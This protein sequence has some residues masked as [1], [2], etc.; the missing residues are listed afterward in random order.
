M[1]WSNIGF[2]SRP[3]ST[4][5]EQFSPLVLSILC[6]SV[7]FHF[8]FSIL[9]ERRMTICYRNFQGYKSARGPNAVS[10]VSPMYIPLGR[11]LRYPGLGSEWEATA[12]CTP[13]LFTAVYPFIF[14]HVTCMHAHKF[15]AHNLTHF[16]FP[17][18]I[19]V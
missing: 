15:L 17:L 13:W 1:T 5:P 6:S 2:V 19:L 10:G 11:G 16:F 4:R 8:Q 14:M 9:L 12:T 7:E 18:I 3:K